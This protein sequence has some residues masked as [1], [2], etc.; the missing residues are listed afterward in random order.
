[1]E[2]TGYLRVSDPRSLYW[3]EVRFT[4]DYQFEDYDY[5]QRIKDYRI[6]PPFGKYAKEGSPC[7]DINP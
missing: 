5:E 2:E 1:M 4:P 6:K 7:L 3:D